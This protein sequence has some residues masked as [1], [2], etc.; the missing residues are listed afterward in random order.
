VQHPYVIEIVT[1]CRSRS[2]EREWQF[3][4][5]ISSKR[6]AETRRAFRQVNV[7]GKKP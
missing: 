1:V 6:M 7:E 3:S 2:A 5:S 4:C